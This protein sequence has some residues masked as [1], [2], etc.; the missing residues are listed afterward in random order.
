M[1]N[2]I[3]EILI[4]NNNLCVRTILLYIMNKF[5]SLAMI[6][7][8]ISKWEFPHLVLFLQCIFIVS[9]LIIWLIS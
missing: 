9:A 1:D 5:A 2:V 4:Y 8:S 6:K 7:N 3:I